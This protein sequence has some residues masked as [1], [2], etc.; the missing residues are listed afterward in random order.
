MFIQSGS[1]TWASPPAQAV[2]ARDHPLTVLELDQRRVHAPAADDGGRAAPCGSLARRAG[3]RRAGRS[4]TPSDRG[5]ASLR[6]S[7]GGCHPTLVALRTRPRQL[8]DCL[9]STRRR[10]IDCARAGTAGGRG[11]PARRPGPGWSGGQA[12]PSRA[13]V[14]RHMIDFDTTLRASLSA[15]LSAHPRHEEPLDG[16]RHAAVAVVVLDSDAD[17]DDGDRVTADQIDMSV[18]PGGSL[19]E[20]GR[21]LDGRMVGVAGGAAFLLCRRPTTMRRAR[22]SMGASRRSARRRRDA[23]RRSAP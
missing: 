8:L 3:P 14:R 6:W 20:R 15:N 13:D 17:R 7:L 4:P 12:S 21:P 11:A 1:Y 10:R 19:D 22:R 2:A 5:S 16:R 23:A 9:S 18:V